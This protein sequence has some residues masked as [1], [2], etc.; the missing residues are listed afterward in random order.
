MYSTGTNCMYC[1]IWRHSADITHCRYIYRDILQILRLATCHRFSDF[2]QHH[3]L[4]HIV[5]TGAYCSDIQWLQMSLIT[6]MS[7][8][9]NICDIVT[10]CSDFADSVCY[11]SDIH[12][13]ILWILQHCRDIMKHYKYCNSL[14]RHMQHI[15]KLC[16]AIHEEFQYNLK[17]IYIYII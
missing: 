4:W 3:T 12:S 5:D 10:Y 7:T 15:N 1:N 17:I 13:D 8:A 16:I 9:I 2:L 14:Q 6:E 11:C